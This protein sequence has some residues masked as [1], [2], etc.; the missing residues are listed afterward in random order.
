MK[1]YHCDIAV[2]GAGIVGIATAYYLKQL[3]PD[4][5]V[6]LIDPVEPMSFTS[7]QS[8]E[9]YRNW[10]P[11]PVMTSFT[12]HSIDLMQ[13]I[14]LKTTNRINMMRR[15][16]LLCSR[17]STI[18]NLLEALQFGYSQAEAGAEFIR[19][20]NAS[21]N[22][23]YQAPHLPDW[24]SAPDGVDILQG[25]PLVQRH[26]AGVSEDINVLVHIR[27]AGSIDSHSLGQYMLQCY[28][29]AGGERLLNAVDSI[30]NTGSGFV[31]NVNDT[32]E[33]A[34]RV[35]ITATQL[36]NAA[37]P[38]LNDIAAMVGETL[39]V[40]NILQ[41]KIAFEDVHQAISRTLPFCIDLD[42]QQIDWTNDERDV[43]AGS[44]EYRWLTEI[45]PGAIHCRPDGGDNGKWV[46]LGWAFNDRPSS[47]QRNPELLDAFPEIVIRGA[48]RMHPSL[49]QYY[50][51]LPRA[52]RHYG[53]YYTMTEENWPLVGAMQTEGAFVVGA[54]SGFGT[55][56]ACA[57]GEL[58]ARGVLGL[59]LPE[60]AAALSPA[61]YGDAALMSEL[62]SLS[63]K[64][65]L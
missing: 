51:S 1:N 52:H 20:H 44:S 24:Q 10:W 21:D 39:P 33:N 6:V 27:R 19:V 11:H 63:A 43:L 32:V 45:M 29:D 62:A 56:A 40:H 58:C 59:P 13:E 46:K 65:V 16:Y 38:Y 28:K 4:V 34:S 47:V 48:A 54:M 22:A 55:M 30:S 8:G 14:A 64:G 57:G 53:G 37:G 15:G 61:R 35:S 42:P 7:A 50:N 5:S 49:K 12:D 18:D 9:N 25:A 41:Q 26:F 17:A 31:I 60:Y 3:K 36:V 2:I 23:A